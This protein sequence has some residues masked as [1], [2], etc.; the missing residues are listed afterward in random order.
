MGAGLGDPNGD[1]LPDLFLTATGKNSLLSQLEDG[2]FVDV[3]RATGADTLDGTLE[4]MA[5]GAIFTDVDNDGMPDILVAE[6]D[7]WHE[8]STEPYIADMPLNLI[9][10]V[11]TDRFEVAN[12]LGF[13]QMGSWRSVAAYDLNEDG[14]LDYVVGDVEERPMVLMSQSCTAN[15]WLTVAAPHGSRVEVE[16]GGQVRVGWSN[17]ASSF[18]AVVTPQTHFGLGDAQVVSAIKVVL[19]SG[20]TVEIDGEFDARRRVVVE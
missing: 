14:V 16:A 3:G 15:G 7:L 19:P 2:T 20:E 12:E 11:A 17:T 6:G 4:T 1:G 13:G 9:R 5:W 18:G 8:F 10:Q